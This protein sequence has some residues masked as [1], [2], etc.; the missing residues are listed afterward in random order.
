MIA[1]LL[2][3]FTRKQKVSSATSAPK[4]P[5]LTIGKSLLVF[6]LGFPFTLLGIAMLN[7]GNDLG[8]VVAV[9]G[10]LFFFLPIP[11]CIAAIKAQRKYQ[12]EKSKWD[13]LA[14]EE[15]A[16]KRYQEEH[17]NWQAEDFYQAAKSAGIAH[18]NSESNIARLVLFAQ[19]NNLSKTKE[20]LIA[21]YQLGQ[22]EVEYHE[23]KALLVTLEAE[24]QKLEETNLRYALETYALKANL[25]CDDKIHS[26]RWISESAMAA[27]SDIISQAGRLAAASQQKEHSWAIHGGI[28]NGIAGPAAGV[29]AAANIQ[30]ENQAIRQHNEEITKFYASAA[31]MRTDNYLSRAVD[32]DDE[33][34]RWTNEKQKVQSR[35]TDCSDAQQLL[36]QLNPSV[37]NQT[38]SETGAV[39][40][41]IKFDP[42]R[43]LLIYGD[44]PA[45][46]DGSIRV[47]LW[48]GD[49]AAGH[50]ICT[51]PYNG[52]YF[53]SSVECVCRKPM[54]NSDTYLV[55]FEPNHLWA[56]ERK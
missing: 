34:E 30:R 54:L 25:Y 33:V 13:R 55:T 24:E 28:A 46:I 40:L 20:Q 11:L 3:V 16:R 31:L 52:V 5:K 49:K 19:N 42:N 21:D 39:R 17:P 18:L 14:E 15:A 50:A 23:K 38:V 51:L 32:A 45:S 27:R 2:F 6:L 48:V 4:P 22:Q 35:L 43:D 29:A 8:I 41:K 44:V 53:L 36:K 47:C 7:A 26:N 10:L 12:I 9:F 37:G 56:V 1:V